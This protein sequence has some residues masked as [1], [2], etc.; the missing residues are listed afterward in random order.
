MGVSLTSLALQASLAPWPTAAAARDW[1]SS[2]SN[3]HGDNARPLN[4]VARLSGW[5]TAAHRDG[6]HTCGQA[7]RVMEQGKSNLTDA[8]VLAS[9]TTSSGS[10][11]GTASTGQLNPA[12]SLWLMGYPTEWLSCAP[13]ATRSSLKSRPS[14]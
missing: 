7:K 10:P 8:A 1:K 3:K 6:T 5:P 2:A 12:F 11:A 13:S 4:E 14:S 9:G